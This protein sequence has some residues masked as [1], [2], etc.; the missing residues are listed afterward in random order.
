[1][2]ADRGEE[3]TEEKFEARRGWLMRLRERSC[4]YNIK[5]QGETSGADV[6]ALA[7]YPEI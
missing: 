4:L 2:T 6:E 5:M 7:S 1:M 3:A